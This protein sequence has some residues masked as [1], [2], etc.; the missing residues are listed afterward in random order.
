MS[1]LFHSLLLDPLI[2]LLGFLYSYVGDLGI[3]IIILTLLIRS[4]LAPLFYKSLRQQA[5]L[6][7]LQPHIKHIQEKHKGNK[8]EQGQALMA[9]YKEHGVN[10]LT[11]FALLFV[12]L[13]ILIALY[14]VFLSPPPGLGQSF[15]GLINLQERS[16][17]LV[18]IAAFL[19]YILG[20]WSMGKNL[21]H[22]DPGA[23]IARNMI[24]VGPVITVAVLYSLPAAVGL[25]WVT[26]TL[27]SL[28][29]QMHVN[30]NYGTDTANPSKAS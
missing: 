5:A 12:Q 21:S 11:S 9:L 13:P 28:A 23:K 18:I 6:R 20:V 19:Q 8:E 15:L 4:A 16:I 1:S 25:Y 7:K 30:R 14:Q 17:I 10:P 27:Y 22:D 24:V 3:S 29:Q 2:A 26:T